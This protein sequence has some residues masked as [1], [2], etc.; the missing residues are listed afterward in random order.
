ML[1]YSRKMKYIILLIYLLCS[2]S[3]LQAEISVIPD[4]EYF[5]TVQKLIASAER[6][7]EVEMYLVYSNS[8][9]VKELLDEIIEAKESFETNY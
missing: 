3:S 5:D 4:R 9:Q 7:I 8:P 2:C 6:S 1:K